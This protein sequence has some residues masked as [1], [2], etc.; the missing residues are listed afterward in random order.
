METWSFNGF[1]V[2]KESEG[3]FTLHV[4]GIL[5]TYLCSPFRSKGY[6]KVAFNTFQTVEAARDWAVANGWGSL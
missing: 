2:R 3:V 1:I 6:S 5:S 4:K